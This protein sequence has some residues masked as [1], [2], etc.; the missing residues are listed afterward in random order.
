MPRWAAEQPTPRL[1]ARR[2]GP[3]RRRHAGVGNTHA[4]AQGPR[5]LEFG[6]SGDRR[7]RPDGH[8]IRQPRRVRTIENGFLPVIFGA[9]RAWGTVLEDYSAT[10]TRGRSARERP[11]P[12]VPV[13]RT[14]PAA[15]V[16]TGRS[17]SIVMSFPCRR[18]RAAPH[19]DRSSGEAHSGPA[20]AVHV[21]PG[22]SG[23]NSASRPVGRR[24]RPT[25]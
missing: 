8:H 24:S 13:E 12:G 25:E 11:V 16:T 20:P 5:R 14:D 19:S 6:S 15:T 1:A 7:L 9:E 2:T 18:L 10:V 4:E 23:M 21:A 22:R 3:H 17:L